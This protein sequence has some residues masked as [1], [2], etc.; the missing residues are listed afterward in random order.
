M[1]VVLAVAAAILLVAAAVLGPDSASPWLRGVF[2]LAQWFG[3]LLALAA[4]LVVA[5]TRLIDWVNR[6][7]VDMTGPL[8]VRAM[9]PRTVLGVVLSRVYGDSRYSDIITGL[10]GGGGNDPDGRDTAVSR[11]TTAQF[12]LSAVDDSSCSAE[13][14]WTHKYS[15]VRNNH[16]F[17]VFVTFDAAIW[18]VLSTERV[19]PL[20][21]SWLL[22]D[23]GLFEEFVPKMQVGVSYVD[24]DGVLQTVEPA[25]LPGEEIP[26]R[27]YDDFVRLREGMDRKNLRILQ[28]DLWD[29]AD[30][31]HVISSIESVSVRAS[32]LTPIS[33]GFITW[34]APHPCFVERITFDVVELA[35][36]G[37]SFVFKVVPFTMRGSGATTGSWSELGKVMELA[38]N[39]WMLPGHGVTLLWRPTDRLEKGD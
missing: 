7:I 1:A 24:Q 5:R 35:P 8:I 16:K 19:F 3:P 15:G 25:P 21:E 20:Y 2:L 6:R 22:T 18:N 39:D 29:L 11:S 30:P 27:Q 9:P 34:S 14:T 12:R 26:L 38:V 31:D 10:L 37:Q 4:A 36:K 32:A 13:V 33:D 28:F 23:E 17:I